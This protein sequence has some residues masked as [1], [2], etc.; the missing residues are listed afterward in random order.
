MAVAQAAFFCS[1]KM[2]DCVSVVFPLSLRGVSM[3]S[4]SRPSWCLHGA[5]TVSPWCLHGV[6]MVSSWCLHR[7]SGLWSP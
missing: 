5:F 3:V 7:V 1:C 2:S 4:P 6:L